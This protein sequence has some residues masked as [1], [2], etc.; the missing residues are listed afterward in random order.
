LSHTKCFDCDDDDDA[1]VHP[2][3]ECIEISSLSQS[4]RNDMI[5]KMLLLIIQTL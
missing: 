4:E 3:F 1:A 2:L 5:N